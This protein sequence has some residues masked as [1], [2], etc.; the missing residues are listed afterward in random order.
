MTPAEAWSKIVALY[1]NNHN[2]KEEIIYMQDFRYSQRTFDIQYLIFEKGIRK[3][4]DATVRSRYWS[5]FRVENFYAC[6]QWWESLFQA[7]KQKSLH[8]LLAWK[9]AQG[10]EK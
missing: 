5:N 2:K 8:G 1:N 7:M 3:N 6:S 4:I 10:S 9:R